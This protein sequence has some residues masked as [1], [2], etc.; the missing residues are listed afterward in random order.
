MRKI[1]LLMIALFSVNILADDLTQN[2]DTV[3]SE[4]KETDGQ[5]YCNLI[6]PEI[7]K[8]KEIFLQNNTIADDESVLKLSSVNI[9]DEEKVS[10]SS[11]PSSNYAKN[12]WL[13]VRPSI[14]QN[15]ASTP[16]KTG[17]NPD[18]G[19]ATTQANVNAG[20]ANDAIKGGAANSDGDLLVPNDPSYN[21][22]KGSTNSKN[23]V[24]IFK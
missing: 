11:A 21:Q 3:C 1:L 14:T 4:I 23:H 9:S 13:R 24:N 19:Y 12:N 5:K 15:D 2:L 8:Q 17:S 16:E 18:S 20:E 10:V 7:Q 22:L 6:V